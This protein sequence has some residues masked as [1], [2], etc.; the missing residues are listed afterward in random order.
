M[1]SDIK[2]SPD[3]DVLRRALTRQGALE[4]ATMLELKA[5]DEIIAAVMGVRDAHAAGQIEKERWTRLLVQFWYELG[6]DAVRLKAGLD[7]PRTRIAADDTAAL[8][9]AKREWQSESE[10]PI[11][12]WAE[13]EQYPWPTA[14]DANFSQIE[15]A[16]RILPEG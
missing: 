14:N 16:G 2:P 7:L 1:L 15:L 11:A 12:N 10:G 5:D 13:F 8:A 9:R 3:F 4:R 6:Y